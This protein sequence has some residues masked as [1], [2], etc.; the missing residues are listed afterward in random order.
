VC[1]EATTGQLIIPDTI[2]GYPVTS[3]G[4]FAF[5]FCSNLTSI[6]IPDS[7]TIIEKGPSVTAA[8]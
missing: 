8:A 2:E 5:S 4:K 6:T 1:D 7:V 3:I